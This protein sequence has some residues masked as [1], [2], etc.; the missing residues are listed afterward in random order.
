MG[1]MNTGIVVLKR[2]ICCY[3]IDIAKSQDYTGFR[4]MFKNMMILKKLNN[5]LFLDLKDIF[6]LDFDIL[7]NTTIYTMNHDP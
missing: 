2:S 7:N 4:I 5:Q 3:F 1:I 6:Y